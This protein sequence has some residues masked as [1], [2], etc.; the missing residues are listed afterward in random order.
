MSLQRWKQRLKRPLQHIVSLLLK[1]R[2]YTSEQ[3]V[4]LDI[5]PGFIKL[6]KINSD[7]DPCLVE[8]FGIIPLPAGAIA[9]EEI[10]NP[11]AI[12][13][14]LSEVF[15][16]AGEKTTSLAISIPR[17]ST[18]IKTI[19][20]DSRLDAADIES[21]AWIEASHHFPDL[22]GDIYLDFDVL[23]PSAQDPSLLDLLL[24]A[25]RKDQ[26]KPYL[27]LLNES[28]FK[29]MVVDINC[30]ALERAL[31]LFTRQFPKLH[32]VALLNLDFNLSSLVV[33]H[34]G[35]MIYAHDHS[36]DGSNF[37]NQSQQY[38]KDKDASKI[39]LSDSAYSD[40]LKAGLSAHLRHS[41][42]FFY[43]SRPHI[44]IEKLVLSGDCSTVPCLGAFIQQE[45]GLETVLA[46]PFVGMSI[47]S[48]VDETMLQKY[49][50]ALMLVCGLALSKLKEMES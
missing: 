16:D 13:A 45:T 23:G 22:V 35:Q 21:R 18:I 39:S 4:G 20:V 7:E 50:S 33:V 40:I 8:A 37:I 10:K 15:E 19:T 38:L 30:Y 3:L 1:W 41:M 2:H 34:Q 46:E 32:T 36:Y 47:E 24:V 14:A 49:S 6:L 5:G 44:A 27:D 26:V 48:S 43:S 28:G 31:T 11:Q 17:S 25:C 29:V 12:K 42:H 9:K